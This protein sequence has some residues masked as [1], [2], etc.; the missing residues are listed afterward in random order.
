MT[1]ATK[2]R[3]ATKKPLRIRP[4]LLPESAKYGS[5]DG[6]EY[7]MIPVEEFGDWYED[8]Q[9]GAIIQDRRENNNEQLVSLDEFLAELGTDE[10]Q[11]AGK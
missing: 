7:I 6:R 10:K 4:E 2:K 9:D 8:I 5:F 1:T 3:P 11:K